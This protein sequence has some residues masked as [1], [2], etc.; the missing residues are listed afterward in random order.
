MSSQTEDQDVGGET[1]AE[2]Q[3]LNLTVKVDKRG[4]CERHITVTVS[5]EDIDRYLSGAVKE[6]M[7]SAQV[8]GFRPG[9]A[10][11]KLVEHRFHKE[12]AQQVKGSLLMDSLEQIS[13]EQKLAAISEPELDLEAVELPDD[14]PL[15]FEFNLEVRPEFDLPKWKGL[16]VERPMRQFTEKDVDAELQ[17]SL[18]DHGRLI[19]QEEPASLGDYLTVNVTFKNGDAVVSE[20]KEIVVRIRPVLSLRDGNLQGFDKLMTGVKAGDSRTGE[21]TVSENAAK[22]ELRGK[23]LTA[24]FEVLEVK[25]LQLPEMTKELLEEMGGFETEED[26]RNALRNELERRLKYHQNQRARQQITS[27]LLA[28]ADWELPPHLLKKQS[29]RELERSILELRRSGFAEADIRK[30]ENEIRQNAMAITAKN[31]KEH[32]ILERIA[33][34]EKIEDVPEDYDMEVALIAAQS[35]SSV[36]R[37]RAQLEKRGL[38]D[39]LRNQIIERKVIDVVLKEA[40]FKD[41][42]FQMDKT[43]VEAV[44]ESAAGGDEAIPEAQPDGGAGAAEAA[45]NKK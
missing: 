6:I 38:M 11:R 40:T 32:F 39:I 1:P 42:P 17:R 26:L 15:T 5:R 28:G 3:K 37:V 2:K 25:A 20:S 31:L 36:R 12:V 29:Q 45:K 24:V 41:V 8:P 16:A 9:R 4:A 7:P 44:E 22:E 27:A 30:H 33:E 14:G 19:P 21:I 18:A 23:N 34:E 13:D 10:P 43:D 35:G